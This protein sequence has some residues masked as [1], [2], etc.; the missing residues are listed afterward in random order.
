MR[1]V[2][3]KAAQAHLKAAITTDGHEKGRDVSA[4]PS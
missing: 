3:I 4:A 1:G 2:E